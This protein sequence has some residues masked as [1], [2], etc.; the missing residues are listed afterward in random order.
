MN[1][2][3][4][5][6]LYLKPKTALSGH[7]IS[8]VKKA[9]QGLAHLYQQKELQLRK[10]HVSKRGIPEKE[11]THAL[12]CLRKRLPRLMVNE[13]DRNVYMVGSKSDV[14]EAKQFLGAMQGFGMEK[15]IHSDHPFVPPQS[16]FTFLKQGSSASS[17][18]S[19][20]LPQSFQDSHDIFMPKKDLQDT[21]Q[22]GI[23]SENSSKR[24]HNSVESKNFDD[25][26]HSGQFTF[27][28]QQKEKST[29][30]MFNFRR[31]DVSQDRHVPND[32]KQMEPGSWPDRNK[33]SDSLFESSKPSA[34]H[35]ILDMNE[36]LF[37]K[38]DL[39]SESTER[40]S[41]SDT[42]VI[43][44]ETQIKSSKGYKTKQTESGKERKM[45]ANF[46]REMCSGNKDL[47]SYKSEA[48]K[49]D[50]G[51]YVKEKKFPDSGQPH[52]LPLIM[53]SMNSNLDPNTLRSMGAKTSTSKMDIQVKGDLSKSGHFPYDKKPTMTPACLS[54]DQGDNSSPTMPSRSTLRRSNSFSDRMK[55]G[56]ETAQMS[57][58][59]SAGQKGTS[60]NSPTRE[61]VAMDLVLPFRLWLYLM[62]VYNI[63]I[64]NLTSDL[65]VKEKVVGEDI[66][67]C[68]RGVDSGKVSECHHALNSLI[69]KTEMDFD[70][71]T[72]PLS[73]LGVSDS[74]DKTLLELCTSMKQHY[75][76]VKIL[77]MSN[78]IMILGPK[79]LCD[80][81]E[82]NMIKVFHKGGDIANS[83]QENKKSPN[84]DSMHSSKAPDSDLKL[85][86]DQLIASA[87]PHTNIIVKDLAKM[88]DQS[89]AS[90][91]KTIPQ[92]LTN[93]EQ[94][95]E[96]GTQNK[97]KEELEQLDKKGL[98]LMQGDGGTM[99]NGNGETSSGSVINSTTKDKADGETNRDHTSTTAQSKETFIE[100]MN[101]GIS[102]DQ[103]RVPQGSPEFSEPKNDILPSCPSRNQNLLL[104]YVC[105]KECSTV[106]EA[107]CGYYFCPMCEKEAHNS[108]RICATAGIKGTMSI[109]ESTITIPGFNRD[110]TLKIIYDIPDGI[111]GVRIYYF[112]RN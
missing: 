75:K 13:E 93:Q 110:T 43:D 79:P 6:T 5:T 90:S 109:Q 60:Q 34:P 33:Y 23:P 37:N 102:V 50:G 49:L 32:L 106:R 57:V 86:G 15:E 48:P 31:T 71:R 65:Q 42:S 78:D 87:K 98:T 76:M 95:N 11:L 27:P 24:R 94:D 99:N 25:H 112:Y 107:A 51:A 80:K 100:Q 40:Q 21:N 89:V 22:R 39:I 26:T 52:S 4:I 83:K 7:G 47:T 12:E 96:S 74:K 28:I 41:H 103:I 92:V 82:A 66:T 38:A 1:C 69:A 105:E 104:C 62:S 67:L 8:S 16:K 70:T 59:L 56:E 14:S 18:P 35:S 36:K 77:V 111:Q 64:D 84:P 81:V 9:H 97:I 101:S 91:S 2:D 53:P 46:S 108:C 61:I 72:L 17:E 19:G 45:A 54:G 30:D 88:S 85:F 55:K 44:S 68:L 10:E 20:I 58:D 63:E 29:E 3:D 73:K